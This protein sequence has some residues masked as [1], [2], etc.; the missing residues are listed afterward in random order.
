LKLGEA[1]RLRFEFNMENLFNQKTARNRFNY[2]NRGAGAAEGGSAIDL[3]DTDLRKG[4]N[5]RALI[6]ATGDQR[7]GRGA[8]DPR[9]GLSDIFTPGFAGRFGVK[10]IF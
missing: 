8:Y 1:R 6:N 2:L 7:G 4:F 3:S 9:Y 10:F 5:Y